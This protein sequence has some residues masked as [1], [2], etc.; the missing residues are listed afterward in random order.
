[1]E[2]GESNTAFLKGT[3]FEASHQRSPPETTEP[4]GG[5]QHN[6]VLLSIRARLHLP[7]RPL[8]WL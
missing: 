2:R 5:V 7:T 8:F 4:P 6:R 1:M 3:W